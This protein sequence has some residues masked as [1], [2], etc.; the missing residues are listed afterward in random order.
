MFKFHEQILCTFKCDRQTDRLTDTQSENHKSPPVKPHECFLLP[1]LLDLGDQ[2]KSGQRNENNPQLGCPNVNSASLNLEMWVQPMQKLADRPRENNHN[3]YLNNAIAGSCREQHNPLSR[4]I[5]YSTKKY[6]LFSRDRQDNMKGNTPSTSAATSNRSLSSLQLFSASSS[7][8]GC[9]R[10]LKLT[11]R[12]AQDNKSF[13][14]F[15][16]NWSAQYPLQKYLQAR[17]NSHHHIT[18][19]MALACSEIIQL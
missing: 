5:V 12:K 17:A 19:H 10:T 8:F 1:Y 3:N 15:Y 14:A 11:L 2:L 16:T 7:L 4:A 18:H 9:S 13:N 6:G